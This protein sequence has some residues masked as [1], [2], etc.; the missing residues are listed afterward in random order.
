MTNQFLCVKAGGYILISENPS[1]KNKFKIGNP[2]NV[3][4]IKLHIQYD[5]LIS[6][7]TF[8]K[9]SH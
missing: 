2:I 6:F 9:E 1:K 7:W 8:N 4:E 5:I 3:D